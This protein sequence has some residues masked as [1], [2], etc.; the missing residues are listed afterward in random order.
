MAG[1]TEKNCKEM[2]EGKVLIE[3][4]GT[5][6]NVKNWVTGSY[7]AFAKKKDGN[8]TNFELAEEFNIVESTFQEF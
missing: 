3:L 6:E 1:N 4:K 2:F 5:A 7:I 8:I